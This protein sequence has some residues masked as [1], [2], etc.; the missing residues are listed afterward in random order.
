G[1]P[2]HELALRALLPDTAADVLL[3]WIGTRRPVAGD[4]ELMVGPGV[5]GDLRVRA[6]LAELLHVGST[7]LDA[8]GIVGRS[9]EDPDRAI[10]HRQVAH[11]RDVARGI[12]GEVVREAHARRSVHALEPLLRREERD[13]AALREPHDGDA[14]GIDPRVRSQELEGPV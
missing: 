13:G 7:W 2:V 5:P 10:R 8:R 9:L 1:V 11:V 12:E 14:I 6:G 3:L 4:I